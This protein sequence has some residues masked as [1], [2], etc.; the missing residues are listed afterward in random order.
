M[1][2]TRPGLRIKLCTNEIEY[3]FSNFIKI[4]AGQSNTELKT[5]IIKEEENYHSQINS[6]EM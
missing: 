5:Q 3:Q 1:P 6:P 2:I 4:L